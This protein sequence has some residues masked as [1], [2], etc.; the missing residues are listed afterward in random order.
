MILHPNLR[1]GFS[2]VSGSFLKKTMLWTS[3]ST[4]V[5][6]PKSDRGQYHTSFTHV[7]TQ[8]VACEENN[9]LAVFQMMY[10]HY[11]LCTVL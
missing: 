11:A 8:L 9:M 2:A 6:C 3:Q 4:S 1:Y 7:L 5:S 10:A